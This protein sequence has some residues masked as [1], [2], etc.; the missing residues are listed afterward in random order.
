MSPT[1]SGPLYASHPQIERDFLSDSRVST[2]CEGA[3]VVILD[4][5]APREPPK[6]ATIWMEPAQDSRHSDRHD[7][8]PTRRSC[9][10]ERTTNSPPGFAPRICEFPRRRCLL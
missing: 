6:V 5:F 4:R 7:R 3:S 1:R 10:G 9:A 8:Y 2:G